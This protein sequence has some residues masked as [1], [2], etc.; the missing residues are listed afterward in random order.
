LGRGFVRLAKLIFGK[1]GVYGGAPGSADKKVKTD[2][3]VDSS[4]FSTYT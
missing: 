4:G 3:A 1:F 2:F